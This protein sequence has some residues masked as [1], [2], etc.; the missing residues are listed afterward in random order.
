MSLIKNMIKYGVKQ[1]IQSASW[2]DSRHPTQG[3]EPAT[4]GIC[5]MNGRSTNTEHLNGNW[6][7]A[8]KNM[9]VSPT[10]GMKPS[11]IKSMASRAKTRNVANKT[12][13]FNTFDWACIALITGLK[14]KNS[15]RLDNK[16]HTSA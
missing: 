7:V 3:I 10:M 14:L 5:D 6:D 4:S 11:R 13:D 1:A 12:E 16:S 15:S 8:N 9:E 2:G